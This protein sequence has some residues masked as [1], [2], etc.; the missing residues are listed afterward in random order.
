MLSVKQGSIKYHFLSF[1]YDSTWDWTLVSNQEEIIRTSNTSELKS[2]WVPHS[3]K[4]RAIYVLWWKQQPRNV[5][6]CKNEKKILKNTNLFVNLFINVYVYIYIYIE[7]ERERGDW[8]V[9]GYKNDEVGSRWNAFLH[10]IHEK[11]THLP[12]TSFFLCVERV[13]RNAHRIKSDLP[14]QSSSY[15][16]HQWI[17]YMG[18]KKNGKSL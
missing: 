7:R 15:A 8:G 1:W 18:E 5:Y 2:Q 16:S 17:L 3:Q 6:V 9:N 10:W 11:V 12:L 13:S 14:L 4:P